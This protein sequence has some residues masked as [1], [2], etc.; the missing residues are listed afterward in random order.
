MPMVASSAHARA[1][2]AAVVAAAVGALVLAQGMRPP[3]PRLPASRPKELAPL[4]VGPTPP[5]APGS[6]EA[7]LSVLLE[8]RRDAAVR[9]Q[10]R[11]TWRVGQDGM[12]QP[13]IWVASEFDAVTAVKDERWEN[14]ADV[15]VEATAPD[16]HVLDVKVPALDRDSRFFLVFLPRTGGLSAGDYGLR[17]TAKPLGA[18]V[19]VSDVHRVTVPPVGNAGQFRVGEALLFRRGP[20]SGPD[21]EPA[22]DLRYHRQER[23]K[24]ETAVAGPVTGRS[25]QLLDRAGHPLRLP[26]AI[27]QRDEAGLT[28]VSGEVVLAPLGQGDFILETTVRRGTDTETRFAAF[29][30]VP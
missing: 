12:A 10:A 20:F 9:S 30:I 7:A 6:A 22:G 23:V 17:V 24:V 28:T 4:S 25:V 1:A 18:T 8:I 2:A 15:V 26:V 5:A 3:G 27:D 16:G 13:A 21:W 11:C 14:G 19:G 29:R